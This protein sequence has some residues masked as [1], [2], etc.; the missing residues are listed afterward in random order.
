[1]PFLDDSKPHRD[2]LT[3]SAA[4]MNHASVLRVIL[5]QM[6]HFLKQYLQHQPDDPLILEIVSLTEQADSLERLAKIAEDIRLLLK[7]K[8]I[9][10][11]TNNFRGALRNITQ[12]KTFAPDSEED[13]ETFVDIISG[14]IM[15]SLDLHWGRQYPDLWSRWFY[16]IENKNKEDFFILGK[17]FATND[18]VIALDKHLWA[19]VATEIEDTP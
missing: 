12:L 14:L 15:A 7:S 6:R 13:I 1:M 9:E 17:Y 18:E 19:K 16:W 10:A 2:H 3:A 5:S 8:G 11:G 4:H